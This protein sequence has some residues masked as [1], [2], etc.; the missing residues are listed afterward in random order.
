MEALPWKDLFKITWK[1]G[2]RKIEYLIKEASDRPV[3][4]GTQK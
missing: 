1:N 4:S 2:E 3:A